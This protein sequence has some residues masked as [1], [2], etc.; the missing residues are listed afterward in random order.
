MEFL[1]L[2]DIAAMRADLILPLR[3]QLRLCLARTKTRGDYDWDYLT[4]S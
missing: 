2:E 1:I 3:Y 4:V